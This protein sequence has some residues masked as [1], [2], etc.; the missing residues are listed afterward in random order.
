[1]PG[2]AVCGLVTA[3]ERQAALPVARGWAENCSLPHAIQPRRAGLVEF[4]T[5]MR[6]LKPDIGLVCSYSLILPAE[7]FRIPAKG[8]FNV[9]GGLL[10]EYRGANV[11]NWVL[12][13]G[14]KQTE[15][16][17]HRVTKGIDCGPVVGQR[18]V[19][20]EFNDSAVTL[21]DKLNRAASDLVR[22]SWPMLCEDPVPATPQDESRA[23][24]WPRRR[25]EDGLIDWN[26]PATEIY[27]LIRALVAPWPGAFYYDGDGQKIV[28]N[29]F[30]PMEDVKKMQLDRVGRVIGQ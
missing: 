5:W 8:A 3:E 2:D 20:V 21:R 26:R 19:P 9:H 12:I 15:V 25:P 23:R 29:S 24:S 7:M 27:N 16:T 10:P 28:I 4:L 17:L 30:V 1:V 18:R 14:E 6:D 22:D 11:L 13:N